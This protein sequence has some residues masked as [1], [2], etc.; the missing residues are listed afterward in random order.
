MALPNPLSESTKHNDIYIKSR[1]IKTKQKNYYMCFT[2]CIYRRT[3]KQ[4]TIRNTKQN[5]VHNIK[6]NSICNKKHNSIHS[7][8][9]KRK[10]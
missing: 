5:S 4:N 7:T 8:K 9:Q 2:L 3:N 1:I 10:R 6:H